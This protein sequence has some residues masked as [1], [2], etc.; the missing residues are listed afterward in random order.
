[1]RTRPTRHRSSIRIS[2]LTL[3]AAAVALL[4]IGPARPSHAEWAWEGSLGQRIVSTGLDL[5]IVRPLA[6][7]RAVIG[8]AIFVPAAVMASPAC[9]VN[10][11][12]GAECGPAFEA[13][14]DVLVSEPVD[15][16]FRRKMGD[17]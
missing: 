17:L 14:Y 9:A 7:V 10:L 8:S 12:N 16:A 13:P 6:A 3:M 5:T 4:T 2:W 1:M 15:Y 11:I